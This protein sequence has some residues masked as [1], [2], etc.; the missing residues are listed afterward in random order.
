MPIPAVLSRSHKPKVGPEDVIIGSAEISKI[1][2]F[3]LTFKLIFLPDAEIIV[4]RSDTSVSF[5]L[6]A[7]KIISPLIIFYYKEGDLNREMK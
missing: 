2:S 1:F 4:L 7:L 3:L 5:L 6:S